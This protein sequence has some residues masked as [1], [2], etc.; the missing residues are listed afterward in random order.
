MK[1]SEINHKF[2]MPQSYSFRR[3]TEKPP[4]NAYFVIQRGF[5]I[6]FL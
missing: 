5:N 1:K 6:T 3:K 2:K 4:L